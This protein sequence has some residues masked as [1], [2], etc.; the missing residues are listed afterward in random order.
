M[1]LLWGFD[2]RI[3]CMDGGQVGL[4]HL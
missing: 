3:Q 4:E 1:G 2:L